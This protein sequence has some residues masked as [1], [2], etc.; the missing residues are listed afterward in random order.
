MKHIY[1]KKGTEATEKKEEKKNT[2]KEYEAC[3]TLTLR[4]DKDMKT[5]CGAAHP[6]PY[7]LTIFHASAMVL[8]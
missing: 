5:E 7:K 6:I 1:T 2:H 4:I 8:R 3:K